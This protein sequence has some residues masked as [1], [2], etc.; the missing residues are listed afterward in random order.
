M[1]LTSLYKY[2]DNKIISTISN[3]YKSEPN[4]LICFVNGTE[5]Y[6]K[7]NN[8]TKIDIGD[9][10]YFKDNIMKLNNKLEKYDI[11]NIRFS[12]E[13]F[14]KNNK[15]LKLF[16]EFIN[17]HLLK[18]GHLI[19]YIISEEKINSYL[20]KNINKIGKY[21]LLPLYDVIDTFSSYGKEINISDEPF[22]NVVYVVDIDEVKLILDKY[23]IKLLNDI[24]I[25]S[26][27]EKF[28][29]KGGILYTDD[30]TTTFMCKI[31]IF[32]K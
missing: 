31:Y 1:G 5:H 17:E 10:K 8:I 15:D 3:K 22:D 29:K 23:N 4:I 11:I 26:F 27:V 13:Y 21:K 12:I 9:A 25:S 19:M 24:Y 32:I 6:S 28:M 20:M 30:L 16:I 7:K 18:N 14:F 2:I